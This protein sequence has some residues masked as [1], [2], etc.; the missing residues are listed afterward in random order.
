[1]ANFLGIETRN[2]IKRSSW[3]T[4]GDII[5]KY[6]AYPIAQG[7]GT[8]IA[9]PRDMSK[10]DTAIEQLQTRNADLSNVLNYQ[11]TAF[12]VDS[13][14]KNEQI[15]ELQKTQNKLEMDIKI[16]QE[17]MMQDS[18]EKKEK[19]AT[20]QSLLK[21]S[22]E[23]MQKQKEVQDK[24]ADELKGLKDNVKS[25]FEGLNSL[26]NQSTQNRDKLETMKIQAEFDRNIIDFNTLISRFQTEQKTLLGVIV[27][28]NKGFLD[29]YIITPLNLI[30]MMTTVQSYLPDG[31]KFP[32][33]P[34]FENARIIY[35]LIKPEFQLFNSN[36]FFILRINLVTLETFNLYKMTS[37]P[38]HVNAETYAF[39]LPKQPYLIINQGDEDYTLVSEQD[40]HIS[41]KNIKQG[42]YLC[43][44]LQPNHIFGSNPDCEVDIFLNRAIDMSNCNVRIVSLVDTLFI[45]LLENKKW[46]YAAPHEDELIITCQHERKQEILRKSGILQL[47]NCT[48]FKNHITLEP[49]LDPKFEKVFGWYIP[50]MSLQIVDRSSLRSEKPVVNGVIPPFGYEQL[51]FLSLGMNEEATKIKENASGTDYIY[52]TILISVTILVFISLISLI[53]MFKQKISDISKIIYEKGAV[54]RRGQQN[55]S[56]N[57]NTDT[58]EKVY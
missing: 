2:R 33:Y 28:V 9:Q 57:S 25:I 44:R 15:E 14:K 41:C 24:Q 54:Q 30:E 50:N 51:K 26:Q 13:E 6:V 8:R 16:Q 5:G 45:K 7:I 43:A 22:K 37:L 53:I 20:L 58:V 19:I 52:N 23:K 40:L 21:E 36:I 17:T 4:W 11:I 56:F 29:P 12:R 27:N 55:I 3:E 31:H 18:Q 47:K 46:I 34:N 10:Y 38:F 39:V 1:M 32:V 48:A 49:Y 42:E 35:K